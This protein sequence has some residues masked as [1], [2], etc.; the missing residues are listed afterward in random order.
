MRVSMSPVMTVL[1]VAVMV[2]MVGGMFWGVVASRGSRLWNSLH[3][4]R[5]RDAH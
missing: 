2:L 1:M 3:R 5:G 4:R